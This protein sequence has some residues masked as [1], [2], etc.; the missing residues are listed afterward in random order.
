MCRDQGI[1]TH[2]VGN[3]LPVSPV[4]LENKLGRHHSSDV[5]AVKGGTDTHGMPT[6]KPTRTHSSMPLGN[7]VY[8][9]TSRMTTWSGGKGGMEYVYIYIMC[10]YLYIHIYVYTERDAV[11]GWFCGVHEIVVFSIFLESY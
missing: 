11:E 1:V 6:R 3:G 7:S 4:S 5:R 8:T 10:T 2:Y 9:P